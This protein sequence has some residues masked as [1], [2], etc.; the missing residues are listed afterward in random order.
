MIIFVQVVRVDLVKELPDSTVD[1][2]GHLP[3][4]LKL[5]SVLH[6]VGFSIMIMIMI[7]MTITCNSS[8]TLVP[9]TSSATP[10]AIKVSETA[11]NC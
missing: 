3:D 11:L 6:L 5:V 8:S 4:P 1:A 2:T 7:I 9:V 10:S